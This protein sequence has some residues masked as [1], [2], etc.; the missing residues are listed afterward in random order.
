MRKNNTGRNNRKFSSVK[1][2]E[3]SACRAKIDNTFWTMSFLLPKE[4]LEML[5]VWN[6][7]RKAIYSIAV[8]IRYTTIEHYASCSPIARDVPNFHVPVNFAKT[9]RAL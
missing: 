1:Q 9:R 8:F 6:K 3:L 4:F 2:L 5:G 7:V